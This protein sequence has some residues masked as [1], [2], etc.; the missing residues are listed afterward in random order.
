MQD[1]IYFL[2][3]I[4]LLGT[5]WTQEMMWMIVH[6]LNMVGAEVNIIERFPFL[7]YVLLLIK[8]I[9]GFTSHRGPFSLIYLLMKI[10]QE[11]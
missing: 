1:F 11:V 4:I 8:I 6:N 10:T 2:K 3:Q 5:T 7:E 9:S